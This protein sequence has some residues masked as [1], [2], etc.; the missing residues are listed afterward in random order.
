MRARLQDGERGSVLVMSVVCLS[1]MLVLGLAAFGMVDSGEKRA[2]EQRQRET[3]LNLAEAVLYSQGFTL[4]QAWPGNATAGAAIPVTCTSAAVQATC[5]NPN[6]LAAA[7]SATPSAANFTSADASADVTWTTRIR[8]NGAPIADAFDYTLA[9]AAQSGVNTKTGL[10]YACATPCRWDANGDL[11][12]WVQARAVVRGKPRNI[13]ALLKRE[14]FAEAFATSGVT[15]GSLETT[16]NGNKA[17]IDATGSQV[18]VRCTTTAPSCTDYEASKGQILPTTIV[19]DAATPSA[20][21]TTQIARFKAAA[22]SASPST[23]YTSCP[24][25]L[26]GAVVFIDVPA[27]TTC[28]DSNNA[29]YNTETEPG[30]VMMPRGALTMKGTLHGIVYMANQQ[31][32]TGPVLTMEANSQILG[33]VAIDGAGRLVVG[34]ASGPRST[35]KY[36][37]LAFNVLSTYGTTG[38]VQ[39]TW[40]ELPPG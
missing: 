4:A 33:G 36:V 26:T 35:V 21:R 5:P 31:N 15:A 14:Q 19:R 17:I 39:N 38:L 24:A 1:A 13:V 3:S 25:T 30:I 16:N 28:T 29:T 7:N 6:T 10:A 37:A 12:L 9:D 34:Q 40:R 22:Q 27:T 8:D 23:Y 11:K 2:G 20:M 18:V 32:T